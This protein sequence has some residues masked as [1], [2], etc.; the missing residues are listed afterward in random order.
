ML[1]TLLATVSTT[2]FEMNDGVSDVPYYL[3][4]SFYLSIVW[5]LGVVIVAA[6]WTRG[7]KHIAR[8]NSRRDRRIEL[9][10][11]ARPISELFIVA[12]LIATIVVLA[13]EHVI[14]SEATAALLGGIAGYV[15]RGFAAPRGS[16]PPPP[17]EP[18]WIPKPPDAPT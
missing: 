18:R 1:E 4:L 12:M 9:N 7:I 13:L 8:A 3:S 11:L 10:M 16:D 2:K 6:C 14:G 5:L 17:P 15:L